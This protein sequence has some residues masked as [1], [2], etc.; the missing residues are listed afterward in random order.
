MSQGEALGTKTR[1]NGGEGRSGHVAGDLC[2]IQR[3]GARD[4]VDNV[5]SPVLG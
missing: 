2:E 4:G 3:G 1:R 5:A